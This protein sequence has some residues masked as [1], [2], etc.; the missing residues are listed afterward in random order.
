MFLIVGLGN[1]GKEYQNTRHNAGFAAIDFLVEHEKLGELKKQKKL[2]AEVSE[3]KIDNQKIILAKPQTFMNNSG[4]AATIMKKFWQVDNKNI[5]I[6]YDELDLPVGKIRVRDE[7]SSAGHN[8]IKSIIEKLGTDKF[9]RVRIGIKNEL[10]EKMEAADFVLS[11]FSR[12][13]KKMLVK[14]IL[15]KVT[16]E[17][18]K[19]IT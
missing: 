9:W 14:E 15:P 5:I 19:I 2:K 11:K 3:S 8:G 13:E 1:P 6:V 10:K 18:K 17:I 4:E 12:E 7:G 16:E